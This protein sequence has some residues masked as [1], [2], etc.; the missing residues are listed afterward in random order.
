MRERG[1]CDG[2]DENGDHDVCGGSAAIVELVAR[3][4]VSRVFPRRQVRICIGVDMSVINHHEH[5]HG[6]M[7]E[8]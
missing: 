1:C 2:N 8:G 4:C 7:K 5:I 6:N 3:E